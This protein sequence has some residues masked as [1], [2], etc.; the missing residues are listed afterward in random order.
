MT[1]SS[2]AVGILLLLSNI[3]ERAEQRFKPLHRA[4]GNYE[5]YKNIMLKTLTFL[6]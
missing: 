5:H 4:A 1:G 3:N 6:S 2:C